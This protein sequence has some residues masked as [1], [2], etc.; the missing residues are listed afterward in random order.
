MGG[1]KSGIGAGK[2]SV[3]RRQQAYY[4]HDS[5]SHTEGCKTVSL[6]VYIKTEISSLKR[7]CSAKI[8]K[9]QSS[10]TYPHAEGSRVEDSV[11]HLAFS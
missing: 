3:V 5:H 8:K 6:V 2:V 10:S 11:L 1:K 7:I 4:Y 9:N